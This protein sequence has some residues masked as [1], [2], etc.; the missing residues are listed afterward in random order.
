[1]VQAY[2]GIKGE[3]PDAGAGAPEA[4]SAE[5][6]GADPHAQNAGQVSGDALA[7]FIRNFQMAGGSVG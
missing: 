2:L 1:M 6:A 3:S 5:V 4:P 7:S